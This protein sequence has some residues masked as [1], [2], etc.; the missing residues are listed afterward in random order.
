MF[1]LPEMKRFHFNCGEN[2]KNAKGELKKVRAHNLVLHPKHVF[3]E[4]PLG[5]SIP[6]LLN[7]P[8]GEFCPC[9]PNRGFITRCVV[10]ALC[11]CKF[12]P[13]YLA[14][15]LRGEHYCLCCDWRI[16][17][18]Y[19]A[20]FGIPLM[21]L[22][23]VELQPMTNRLKVLNAGNALFLFGLMISIN[24]GLWIRPEEF[25]PCNLLGFGASFKFELIFVSELEEEE[26]LFHNDAP[27]QEALSH[28]HC[29]LDNQEYFLRVAI[30]S[31]CSP[32]AKGAPKLVLMTEE[33]MDQM[34]M[35]SGARILN[36]AV[37]EGTSTV[38]NLTM[39]RHTPGV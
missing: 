31:P 26:P 16:D 19:L 23:K 2:L 7:S 13:P 32:G 21:E 37:D 29:R 36:L 28:T 30:A 20:Q 3:L 35:F 14:S 38:M 6:P 18:A 11:G 24:L 17:G 5:Q 4:Y 9:C 34:N 12:H 39:R 25:F 1:E 8:K 33:T 15:L 27:L 22:N 10:I